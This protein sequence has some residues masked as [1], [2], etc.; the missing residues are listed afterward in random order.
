MTEV[1]YVIQA[2]LAFVMG[3]WAYKRCAKRWSSTLGNHMVTGTV[4]DVGYVASEGGGSVLVSYAYSVKG[5]RFYGAFCP[6]IGNVEG[7]SWKT[8]MY[9]VE[10]KMR[11][12][13]P[14]GYEVSVFYFQGSPAEH[15]L[16]NPPSKWVIFWKAT[17]LP[18]VI[19]LVTYLPL[20]FVNLLIFCQPQ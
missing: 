11:Q 13:Y 4:T 7:V 12:R 18:L 19:L 9:E 3:L 10:D 1:L 20:L 14:K 15:W 16:H 17:W 5:T 6:S 2:A 8:S